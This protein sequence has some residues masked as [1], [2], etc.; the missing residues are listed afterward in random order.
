MVLWEPWV[1]IGLRDCC[2][3]EALC[4][5]ADICGTSWYTILYGPYSSYGKTCYAWRCEALASIAGKSS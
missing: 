4:A 1:M 5:H 3:L 2:G